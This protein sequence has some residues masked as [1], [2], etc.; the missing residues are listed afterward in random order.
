MKIAA[1]LQLMFG[2]GAPPPWLPKHAS[3]A[4]TGGRPYK[5]KGLLGIND[6]VG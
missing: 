1:L 2:G 6:T 5:P 3:W 4:A